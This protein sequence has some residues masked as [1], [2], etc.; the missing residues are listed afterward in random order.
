M[1]G[2]FGWHLSRDARLSLAQREAMAASLAASNTGRGAMSWGAYCLTR[3]EKGGWDRPTLDRQVGRMDAVKGIG[4]IGLADVVMGHTRYATRGAITVAN[5]HPFKVGDVTLA[6]N[7][8]IYN[9]DS[10]DRKYGRTC[11]VDSLHL[12]HHLHEG[13]PFS[14]LEGY[15]AIQYARDADPA[16][17]H[18]CRMSGGQLSIHGLG[19]KDRPVGV[20]WSSDPLHLTAALDGAG[21][22][23]FPYEALREGRVYV[24]SADG[25]LYLLPAETLRLDL[26][27]AQRSAHEHDYD[28]WLTGGASGPRPSPGRSLTAGEKRRERRTLRK[29][30]K[31]SKRKGYSVK[32]TRQPGGPLTALDTP[33]PGQQRVVDL[34][35]DTDDTPGE[36]IVEG[37][38]EADI[39]AWILA[40]RT[41][42]DSDTS[43]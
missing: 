12:A 1:C 25:A 3:R 26:A 27:D 29:A 18:L 9:S 28:Q 14:D 6:H 10:L 15:G 16:E 35:E 7:G 23:H 17:V 20:V 2:I 36:T 19:S 21:L 4:T 22:S 13:K 39:N 42:Q 38:S 32:I 11:P 41:G 33:K 30:D 5:C 43:H 34:V 31:A 37:L 40:Q 24:A 8:M